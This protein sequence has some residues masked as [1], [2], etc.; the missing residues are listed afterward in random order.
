MISWLQLRLWLNW[1]TSYEQ[2]GIELVSMNML[3]PK[4]SPQLPS[5]EVVK[6][7]GY[8][9]WRVFILFEVG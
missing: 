8:S 6:D 4:K 9:S 2:S 7:S 3:V 5:A 1:W